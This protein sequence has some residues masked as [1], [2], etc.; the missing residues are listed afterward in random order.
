[1]AE[2]AVPGVGPEVEREP[3][4]AHHLLEL[5]KHC[6]WL[7]R[8]L[9]LA[10]LAHLC[11]VLCLGRRGFLGSGQQGRVL[12]EQL[13]V[14]HLA[15]EFEETQGLQRGVVGGASSPLA[16]SGLEKAEQRFGPL[17]ERQAGFR[18]KPASYR[19][20]VGHS[21]LQRRPAQ[22]PQAALCLR[23]ARRELPL[24]DLK[25]ERE[26]GLLKKLDHPFPPAQTLAQLFVLLRFRVG[27]CLAHV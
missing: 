8:R 18:Q 3:L 9:P 20:P 25:P 6:K 15:R 2:H 5:C 7:C 24:S 26:L 17:G 11:V 22:A 12:V 27:H 13:L 4:L 10:A 19:L 14:L 1:M 23:G 16:L 21:P